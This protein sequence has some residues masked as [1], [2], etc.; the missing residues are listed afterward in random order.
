MELRLLFKTLASSWERTTW[1]P[2]ALYLWTA[3]SV[4]GSWTVMS[5]SWIE[6][7]AP[8]SDDSFRSRM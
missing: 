6:F 2:R 1:M 3:E 7:G 5:P 8:I 4:L